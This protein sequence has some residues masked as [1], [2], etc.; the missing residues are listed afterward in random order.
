MSRRDGRFVLEEFETKVTLGR[1]EMS[2]PIGH[3]LN[4]L[5]AFHPEKLSVPGQ[6]VVSTILWRVMQV[7]AQHDMPLLPL[8]K[9]WAHLG[10]GTYYS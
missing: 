9:Q 8:E 7:P 10:P 2:V 6:S 4:I 5:P 1:D 3:N